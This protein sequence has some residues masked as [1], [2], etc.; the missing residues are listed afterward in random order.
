MLSVFYSGIEIRT[1]VDNRVMRSACALMLFLYGLGQPA[2]LLSRLMSRFRPGRA[3][4]TAGLAMKTCSQ[5]DPVRA[6]GGW[7]RAGGI[8]WQKR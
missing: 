2:T 5:P 6:L 4:C 8:N 7:R 3:A 1:T